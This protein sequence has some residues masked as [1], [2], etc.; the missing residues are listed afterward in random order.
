VHD[1][2]RERAQRRLPSRLARL[3]RLVKVRSRPEP[4]REHR[5]PWS[6][7]AVFEDVWTNLLALLTVLAVTFLSLYWLASNLTLELP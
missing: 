5:M 7:K 4:D 3:V 1:D 2:L 6:P